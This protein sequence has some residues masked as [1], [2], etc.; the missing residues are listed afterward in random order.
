MSSSAALFAAT[1]NKRSDK[2][3]PLFVGQRARGEANGQ[4]TRKPCVANENRCLIVHDFCQT[5]PR[6][7]LPERPLSADET[8][9]DRGDVTGKVDRRI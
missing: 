1:G 8:A 9:G 4:Q 5:V 3:C 2:R 6:L 7:D